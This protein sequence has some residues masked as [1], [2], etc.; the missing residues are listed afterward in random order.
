MAYFNHRHADYWDIKAEK[1]GKKWIIDIKSDYG[2]GQPKVSINN[3]LRMVRTKG[4]HKICLVFIPRNSDI[5]FLFE[6]NKMT[7]ARLKA[8]ETKGKEIEIQAGRKAA[9]TRKSRSRRKPSSNHN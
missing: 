1:N 2:R 7:I 8:S 6:L 4:F 5:L 3:I 9:K